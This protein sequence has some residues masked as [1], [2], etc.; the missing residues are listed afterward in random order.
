MNASEV[1]SDV[2]DV[3]GSIKRQHRQEQSRMGVHQEIIPGDLQLRGGE[4]FATGGGD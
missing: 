1:Q 3:I 2:R 4:T